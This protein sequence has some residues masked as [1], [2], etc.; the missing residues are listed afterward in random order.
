MN[1]LQSIIFIA[2]WIAA[3]TAAVA[4]LPLIFSDKVAYS[5][6]DR[7]RSLVG[8]IAAAVSFGLFWLSSCF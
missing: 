8:I 5:S 7:K 3:L 1:T 2:G 6:A 4:L